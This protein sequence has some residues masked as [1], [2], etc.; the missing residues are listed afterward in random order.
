MML[1]HF[2]QG[3]VH[4]GVSDAL[5][6]VVESLESR[7]YVEMEAG[8][9]GRCEWCREADKRRREFERQVGLR[10]FTPKTRSSSADMG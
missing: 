1:R 2:T 6:A 3:D 8:E 7:G 10:G 4:F 5:P 9:D